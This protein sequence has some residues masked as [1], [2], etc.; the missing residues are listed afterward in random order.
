VVHVSSVAV[1]DVDSTPELLTEVN[2][3]N[4]EIQFAP[5]QWNEL[6]KPVRV[7]R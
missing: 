5:R 1:A 7:A 3:V 6:V 4:A 2:I